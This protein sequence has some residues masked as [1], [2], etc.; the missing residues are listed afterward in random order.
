MSLVCVVTMVFSVSIPQTRGF[1]NVGETMVFATAALF[2]PLT[3]ALAGGIGASVADVLLGYPH[4]AP[5]TLV[6]KACE[7]AVVGLLC[8]A[9]PKFSSR[10]FWRIFTF[11]TGLTVGVL[12]ALIGSI[13]YSGEVTLYLGI[14]PPTDPNLAFYVPQTFWIVVGAIII[15][16]ITLAGFLLEPE[17]GWLVFTMLTGGIVMVSGYYIY[18]KFLIF[19][20]F[21]ITDIIAEAEIPINVGQMII[22]LIIALPV[23]RVVSTSLPQLKS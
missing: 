20:L 19:P 17:F 2:G 18:Q 14:P 3:G 4:Y 11:A 15:A 1:F 8:R 6:I 16:L 12:L 5:A 23:I 13:Y 10:L 7:G 22:G 21:G 9:K